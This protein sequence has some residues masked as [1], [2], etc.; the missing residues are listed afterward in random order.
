MLNKKKYTKEEIKCRTNELYESLPMEKS[1]RMRCLSVRDEVL[2]LN[3]SFFEYVASNTI[4]PNTPYEDK[5]Q[6]ALLAFLEIWW[7]Y[8]W[9][10]KYRDDLS[11]AVFFKPRLTEE[12]RR[13]LG[14]VSYTTKRNLCMKAAA[15][16]NKKWT[17]V[18]YEDLSQVNLDPQ[19]MAA[20]KRILGAPHPVNLED[21]AMFMA[22]PEHQSSIEDYQTT[23]YNSIEELLVQEMIEQEAMLTDRQ[24][25]HL[26]DVYTIPYT[27]LKK[28]LPKSLKTL[29]DRLTANL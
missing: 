6:T 10:P 27:T 13:K 24:L 20:L 4:L 17:D 18:R 19:E 22:A 23:S 16:L 26:S 8:K 28:T 15:Q 5:L 21:V 12:I 25:R 7:K 14:A 3:Y 1:A 29:H 9:A 11:F 2:E